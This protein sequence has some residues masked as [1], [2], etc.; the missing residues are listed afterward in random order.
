M[1]IILDVYRFVCIEQEK[2]IGWPI[3]AQITEC[4]YTKLRACTDGSLAPRD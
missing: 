3:K 4:K 2:I 1:L